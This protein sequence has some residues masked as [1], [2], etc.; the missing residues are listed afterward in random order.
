MSRSMPQPRGPMENN[1]PL[2]LT[3]PILQAPVEKHLQLS[4]AT[5]KLNIYMQGLD[6]LHCSNCI[7]HRGGLRLVAGLEDCFV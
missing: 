3:K 7:P 4:G 2:P 1:N 5:W 6:K